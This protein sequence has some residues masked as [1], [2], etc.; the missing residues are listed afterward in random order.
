MDSDFPGANPLACTRFPTQIPLQQL[1]SALAVLLSL[2]ALLL[3]LLL[4]RAVGKTFKELKI[5]GAYG[6][7]HFWHLSLR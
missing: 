4:T 3:L 5:L 6:K 1:S 2:G 7:W